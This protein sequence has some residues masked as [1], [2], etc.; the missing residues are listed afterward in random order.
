VR[1]LDQAADGGDATEPPASVVARI[2]E[3][4]AHRVERERRRQSQMRGS[5]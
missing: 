4:R 5:A 2:V 1:L 3:A